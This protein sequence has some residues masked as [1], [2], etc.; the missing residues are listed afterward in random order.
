MFYEHDFIIL[1]EP[2]S[3]K[4]QRRIVRFGKMMRLIKSEKALKYSNS[5]HEQCDTLDH[6]IENDVA[7]RIDVWYASRRPDLA[8]VDLIQDLLEGHFY[9]NDRQVKIS[10]SV[11]NLDKDN[12][13]V[14]VRI[15]DLASKRDNYSD[16]KSEELF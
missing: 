3:A 13:R 11:R 4:N 15:R 5:F 7:I 12:P 9:A 2:A 6:L 14:R 8:C 16:L 10:S 1:G